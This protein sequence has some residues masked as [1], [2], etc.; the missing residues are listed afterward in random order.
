MESTDKQV[1]A[2]LPAPQEHPVCSLENGF[3]K[4]VS[5]PRP[6]FHLYGLKGA[7]PIYLNSKGF[8]YAK[9]RGCQG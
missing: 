4:F 7:K 5:D 8:A 2:S 1:S 3:V 9:K 6:T